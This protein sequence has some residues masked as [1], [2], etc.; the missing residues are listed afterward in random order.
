MTG[1]VSIANSLFSKP[2]GDL[3]SCAILGL[4]YNKVDIEDEEELDDH[5]DDKHI[6]PKERVEGSESQSY[7][8]VR[9]PVDSDGN[10]GGGGSSGL[11]EQ[12][13]HEEPGDGAGP[14][15]E[16]DHKEDDGHDGDIRHGRDRFLT[17]GISDI[18]YCKNEL[19]C[20]LQKLEELRR[21]SLS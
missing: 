13:S 10:G 17:F 18:S 6:G 12:L 21:A 20:Y 5:E 4:R 8:E 2:G 7:K 3:L 11:R 15:G 9:R 14:G 19:L 1:L 16:A